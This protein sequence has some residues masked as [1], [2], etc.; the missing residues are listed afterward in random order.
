VSDPLETAQLL[1]ALLPAVR[2]T[3]AAALLAT[4]AVAEGLSGLDSR[5]R[6][7]HASKAG[8]LE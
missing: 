4:L 5:L 3:L 2:W 8:D 1:P 7:G 6:M